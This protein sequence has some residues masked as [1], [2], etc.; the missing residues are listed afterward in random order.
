[1]RLKAAIRP[2]C[3]VF[4]HP[5]EDAGES[6]LCDSG[7]G[8]RG[9]RTHTLFLPRSVETWLVG[10]H[11][12]PY[13]SIDSHDFFSVTCTKIESLEK[14]RQLLKGTQQVG[15]LGYP[16]TKPGDALPC[17]SRVPSGSDQF[18]WTVDHFA[19]ST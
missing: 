19:N 3:K 8:L 1:M 14:L 16:D 15:D 18:Q 12:H 2:E 11:G 9:S 7:R 4:W 13:P 6:H 17:S 10:I 5:R